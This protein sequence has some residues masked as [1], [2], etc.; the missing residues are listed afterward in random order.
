MNLDNNFLKSDIRNGIVTRRTRTGGLH[1]AAANQR[2]P[3]THQ[4]EGA[5]FELASERV[6]D[7]DSKARESTSNQ[8]SAAFQVCNFEPSLFL[9]IDN[10]GTK[11]LKTGRLQAS[12]RQWS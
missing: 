9:F 2:C 8:V 11:T 12:R 4:I 1:H 10:F 5:V 6:V 7:G 3:H